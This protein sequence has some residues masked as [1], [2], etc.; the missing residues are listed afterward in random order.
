MIVREDSQQR[1]GLWAEL[2]PESENPQ[3]KIVV[4]AKTS[5]K[6]SAAR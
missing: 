1:L 3:C 5:R 6:F 4:Y 2:D